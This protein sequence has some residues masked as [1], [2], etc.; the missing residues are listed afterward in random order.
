MNKKASATLLALVLLGVGIVAGAIFGSVSSEVLITGFTAY[1]SGAVANLTIWD[2]TDTGMPYG[3]QIRR[4]NETTYFFANY[5]NI[6]SGEVLNDTI[7]NCTINFTDQDSDMAFNATKQLWEYNRTFSSSG[8]YEYNITCDG[9]GY[10]E[11][12]AS[13]NVLISPNCTTP[14]D[15]LYINSNTTLCPG[16]YYINDGGA[17]GVIIVNGS[18]ITLDCNGAVL[19]GNSSGRGINIDKSQSSTNTYKNCNISNY[20]YGMYLQEL[21]GIANILNS[22]LSSNTYGIYWYYTYGSIKNSTFESNTYGIYADLWTSGDFINSTIKSSTYAI[23]IEDDATGNFVIQ[24]NVI[25]SS[26]TYAIWLRYEAGSG[27]GTKNITENTIYNS[28]TSDLK[29]DSNFDSISNNIWLNHFLGEGVSVGTGTNTDFCINSEGNFYEESISS[30]YIGSDDCGPSNV[31]NPT[32]GNYPNTNMTVNWTRQSSFLDV[33]Y[34]LF[35]TTGGTETFIN[36]TTNLSYF[37]DTSG[38]SLGRYSL[39]VVPWINGSRYNATNANSQ[40]FTINSIPTHDT[41]ILNSSL[42]T[43]TTNENLT[44]HPQNVSD[45]DGHNVTNI[46]NWYRNGISLAVLNMPFDTDVAVITYGAIKDYSTYENNGTLGGGNNNN[47]PTWN[48]S[49][50]IGGAY[51]FDGSDDY[52]NISSSSS[53]NPTKEITMEAW[54]KFD[55]SVSSQVIIRKWT[56]GQQ[57]L[58][59]IY[60]GAGT[61]RGYIYPGTLTD[62]VCGVN[63]GEWYY[64]VVSA[65]TTMTKVYVNGI[66]NATTSRSA[67]IGTGNGELWIGRNPEFSNLPFDGIIDEVR[68]YNIT[69]TPEQIY[70]NYLAGNASRNYDKIVSQETSKGEIWVACITPNDAIDEGV[71]KCSNS[72]TISNLLATA[73]LVSPGNNTKLSADVTFT[74]NYSD[75][76]NDTQTQYQILV[77]NNSNFGSPEVNVTN[78]TSATQHSATLTE[79]QT[80]YWKV[81]VNDSYGWGSYSDVWQLT[82]NSLPTHDNPILSSSLGTNTAGEN[83]TVYPRNVNDL[84]GDNVS[85]ITNWYV[86]GNSVT[87]LNMPFDSNNSAGIGK[88]KDYSPYEND[89][90]VSG[91]THT[92]LGHISGA[93][94]FDGTN[95][96]IM[97]P[98]YKW[99]DMSTANSPSGGIGPDADFDSNRNKVVLFGGYTGAAF[100]NQTWEYDGSDWTQINTNNAP[101]PRY[102]SAVVFDSSRNKI[103]LFGGSPD[104]SNG[105]NDTWE[106]DG[107]DWTQINTA[108]AP[109]AMFS[110]GAMAFD[111]NRNKTVL[112]GGWTGS[113]ALNET[114]EYGGS[115]WTQ[116]NTSANPGAI[117]V[118]ATA[119]D[120]SRNKV[121]LFG[122]FNGAT[123]FNNTWEYNGSDWTQI[124]TAN[125]PSARYVH[126]MA[127]DSSTNRIIL[128]GGNDG[129]NYLNDTWEYN[130]SDWTQINT[131]TAPSTRY[132]HDVS[133]DS[134]RNKIVLFGGSPDGA[135]ALTDTWEYTCDNFMFNTSDPFS[136]EAWVK[137]NYMAGYQ[138][139]FGKV[140]SN[141]GI[142]TSDWG[143]GLYPSGGN[144]YPYFAISDGSSWYNALGTVSATDGNWHH[145]VGVW[146]TT[147]GL[148]YING[149]FSAN[150]TSITSINT[151]SAPIFIGGTDSAGIIQLNGSIDSVRIYNRAL[152]PEQI[153]ALYENR[154]DLIVSNETSL[155]DVWRACI[156]PNDGTGDGTEKCSNNLT[157]V[158]PAPPPEDGD[159]GEDEEI[160]PSCIPSWSCTE[161]QPGVCPP[162]KIQ[163]RTCIDN[164]D[165]GTSEGKPSEMRTCSYT[166]TCDDNIQNQGEEGVDCGGPCPECVECEDDSGCGADEEC[167]DG[168]CVAVEV[169][170]EEPEEEV[171][172]EVEPVE[173]KP[174]DLGKVETRDSLSCTENVEVVIEEAPVKLKEY[175]V[176]GAGNISLPLELPKE[177]ILAVPPFKLECG[178]K[179]AELRIALPENIQDVRA[180]KCARGIC[181]DVKITNITTIT[182]GEDI[183]EIVE[184]RFLDV[185]AMPVDIEPVI[186]DITEQT[187]STGDYKINFLKPLNQT[188]SLEMPSQPLPQPKN[189][190]VKIVGTPL[191]INIQ[192]TEVNLTA[193]ITLP[194]VV[195]NEDDEKTAAVYAKKIEDNE[196]K[197]LYLGGKVDTE[198]KIITAEVNLDDYVQDGKVILAPISIYCP[199]CSLTQFENVFTPTPDSRNAVLL[200][201][202]L[203]STPK[204]W[205]DAVN[206][207]RMTNQPFQLWT[208]AYPTAKPSEEIAEDLA[209]FLEAHQHR[210]DN[211]YIIGH[212]LGGLITQQAVRFA[213]NENKK[214]PAKYSFINN[215]R[216]VI[217]V[218]TPNEGSPL[219]KY[220]KYLVNDFVN[221]EAEVDKYSVHPS[222][223]EVLAEGANVK[224]VPGINYYVIA[225]TESYGFLDLTGLYFNGETNDGAVSLRSAQNIGGEIFDKECENFWSREITHTELTEDAVVRKIVERLIAR[226]VKEQLSMADRK[227]AVMGYTNYFELNVDECSPEDLYIIIGK[228]VKVSE[229]RDELL[230]ACGNGVCAGFETFENCPQDCPL[231]EKPSL[232]AGLWDLIKDKLLIIVGLAALVAVIILS[233][234]E[235][236]P[237]LRPELKKLMIKR[238]KEKITTAEKIDEVA[239]RMGKLDKDIEK[240]ISELKKELRKR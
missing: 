26:S 34:D 69:L 225:G 91:A 180:L 208:F 11:L 132:A 88:T 106:Y 123:F 43:N 19:I 189:K 167:I 35:Y 177:F 150:S 134:S 201:H 25:D 4:A 221:E 185:E 138:A 56:S 229:I 228:E 92:N 128:F 176:M 209:N 178:E 72:L 127:F 76:D 47:K 237:R 66:L 214:D 231:E 107:S 140:S 133:F 37:W 5:T 97:V 52:I 53:L 181:G 159:G 62:A 190:N 63:A 96:Y 236:Y 226:S 145:L 223:Y 142:S 42:G 87:V 61:F 51:N 49:G 60:N 238:P 83:L 30:A 147:L 85:N 20:Y 146:N 67:D 58:Q 28:G 22:T 82:V 232:V 239:E 29:I 153:K 94:S 193:N 14:A 17:T 1:S 188:V 196:T 111:S 202:G 164:N 95:D 174:V 104:A 46:T 172:E 2:E 203:F 32:A 130:G 8:T 50:K 48:S 169:V 144:S 171:E 112:Y 59:L 207:I 222:G 224:K 102:V 90:T 45:A 173:E 124:N 194:Y 18:A 240:N 65:N 154:T 215:V 9:T 86:N 31:T 41:P 137:A 10:E 230:C 158:T 198:N 57:D 157:I 126:D 109:T 38:L 199:H 100:V 64:V 216:T 21:G 13:D 108:N 148:L 115:D 129:S 235:L 77:D 71:K 163:T 116:I 155:G 74:W 233:Y 44:V 160:P 179:T 40:E 139:V 101:S 183:S 204:T 54:V 125:A 136:L 119:F 161:W 117:G 227:E 78:T 27:G 162:T 152:S 80:Y 110:I 120:S 121:V 149:N 175:Q 218:G 170:E 143:I 84:N 212:S 220:L 197:W 98:I 39:R 70:A 36:S 3:D 191:V 234:T 213:Y 156:T 166:P 184:E 12:N 7:A 79:G 217:L 186:G 99:K 182:C 16:T 205:E 68:I 103:V 6:T 33:T 93:Y 81:R 165:C 210:F 200:V 55:D 211:M 206:D 118:Q 73:T 131:S 113:A 89:G 151:V 195:G 15:D 135:N 141:T 122:G 168:V 219:A 114:W 23:T 187:L 24:D 105:L 192:E 75:P